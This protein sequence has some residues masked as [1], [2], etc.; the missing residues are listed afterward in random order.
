NAAVIMNKL[1]MTR[2]LRIEPEG[3]NSEESLPG[4]NQ[5]LDEELLM[6]PEL[7]G[8]L[9]V[10]SLETMREIATVKPQAL[11]RALQCFYSRIGVSG[12][13]E[14]TFEYAG[15]LW[16]DHK[17]FGSL[18]QHKQGNRAAYFVRLATTVDV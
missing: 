13:I 4:V 7:R 15:S 6:E 8:K 9:Q 2:H 5:A 16:H 10:A 17:V 12:A 18:L 14:E 1:A 3:G 11:R